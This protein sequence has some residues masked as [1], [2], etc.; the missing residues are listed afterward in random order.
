MLKYLYMKLGIDIVEIGR[1]KNITMDSTEFVNKILYSDEMTPWNL[2]SICGKM[3][4]KEAIIKT[5]FISVGEWK[6]IKITSTSSGQPQVT[7]D[8]GNNIA[9]R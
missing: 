8:R 9:Y 5:G 4:A 6:K 7:D 1:I 3:A 2:V